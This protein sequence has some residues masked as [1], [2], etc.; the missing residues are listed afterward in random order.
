MKYVIV[1]I[2]IFGIVLDTD[3]QRNSFYTTN[4]APLQAQSYTQLPLGAIRAKGWLLKMLELQRNGLTGNLDVLYP[5][6]CGSTNAW[7]GGNGDAWERGPYWLDGLVPLAYILNDEKLKA[8]AQQWIEWCI[9]TQR[10]DGYFGP[11]S[12]ATPLPKIKG[13]QN[14][15]HEDWWPKMVMLKVL[16]QYYSATGDKRVILLMSKYFNYMLNTLPRTPLGHWTFWG[17]QRGGDNL[18]I[19][20]WLY[21]ITGESFLLELGNLIYQQTTPWKN[22]FTDG[23]LATV[24]PYPQIHCV[25]IAQG[26]KTPAIQFQ[27][28]GDSSY[29]QSIK[30]GLQTLRNVHGFA[31]GMYG[32]DERLHGNNPTQGSELCSAVEMMFSFESILPVTG[33]VYYADYLEKITFNV[34]PTQHND[35][36]TLKQYFQQVNQIKI[37]YDRRNFFND[38]YGRIVFGLLTGYPCCTAN[39]HQGYPKYVQNLWYATQDDGVAAL[40][41]G[42][43]DVTLK[44]KGNKTISFT[45]ETNYPFESS[46]RFRYTSKHNAEFPLHLRIPL[47]CKTGIITVNGVKYADANGGEIIKL[48]RTWQMNDVVNLEL[49][50]EVQLTRWFENSVAVERGPLLYA[51]PL[52]E[53]WVKKTNDDFPQ[54][55]YEVLPDSPWNY[56]LPFH[57]I[58]KKVFTVTTRAV[59]DMPWNINNAPVHL[60][61]QAKQLNQWLEYNHSAG[62]LPSSRTS[63]NAAKLEMVKLIPYGCTTLRIAQFP[64]TD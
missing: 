36:F 15:D 21:N 51:L 61:T 33:D 27:R 14:S 23:T 54:P 12:P 7:L 55:F 42:A 19:V 48:N 9:N 34:L 2:L 53:Q 56:G 50:M 62:P 20:Y 18:A 16:Q 58:D 57:V 11:Q 24:N 25:N 8:K 41:Y 31:N 43:S 10:A 59:S 40:V 17:A 4:K 63:G 47:W 6:V 45:E 22:I 32:G 5:E 46:I 44:V 29:L 1:C 37:T 3:A 64:V 39:M 35:D 13:I 30:Q 52:Q 28:T 60:T 38:N 49:P 26:F